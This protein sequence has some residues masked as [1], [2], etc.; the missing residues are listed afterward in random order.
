MAVSCEINWHSLTVITAGTAAHISSHAS[1]SLGCHSIL[2][3]L[4]FYLSVRQAANWQFPARQTSIQFQS[5]VVI[6]AG[7]SAHFLLSRPC[8]PLYFITLS[9]IPSLFLSLSLHSSL[10]VVFMQGSLRRVGRVWI[11]HMH[12]VIHHIHHMHEVEET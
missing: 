9:Y 1:L 2:S 8:L 7:T 5:L 6:K 3:T 11:N 12:T 4:S 10:D